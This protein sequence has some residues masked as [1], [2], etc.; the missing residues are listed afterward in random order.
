[1]PFEICNTSLYLERAAVRISID[2]M[3]WWLFPTKIYDVSCLLESSFGTEFAAFAAT[4][5][6]AVPAA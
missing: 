1:V 2:L 4:L 6:S 3:T 5:S